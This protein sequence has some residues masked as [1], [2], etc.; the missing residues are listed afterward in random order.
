MAEWYMA[1]WKLSVS[2]IRIRSCRALSSVSTPNLRAA[3]PARSGWPDHPSSGAH[4]LAPPPSPPARILAP[5]AAAVAAAAHGR[6]ACAGAGGRTEKAAIPDDTAICKLQTFPLE[7]EACSSL[8]IGWDG[9]VPFLLSGQR[10]RH[11]TGWL[12]GSTAVG[13]GGFPPFL[14][15]HWRV[16][17]VGAGLG[18]VTFSFGGKRRKR[19]AVYLER[20]VVGVNGKCS[21]RFAQRLRAWIFSSNSVELLS[22]LPTS[23]GANML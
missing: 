10:G 16:Y 5:P 22:C 18:W 19:R 2:I 4:H 23:G 3:A 14:P 6:A 9:G 7:G 21:T 15:F 1:S 17:P 8:R 13:F 11:G 20:E 12:G